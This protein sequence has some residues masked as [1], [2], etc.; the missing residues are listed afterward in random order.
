[1]IKADV[2]VYF[3]YTSRILLEGVRKTTRRK[4]YRSYGVEIRTTNLQNMKQDYYLLNFEVR[5]IS[6]HREREGGCRKYSLTSQK[7]LKNRAKLLT[8][9]GETLQIA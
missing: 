5:Q 1:M 8:P 3:M 7:S 4:E 9:R 2:V 6:F